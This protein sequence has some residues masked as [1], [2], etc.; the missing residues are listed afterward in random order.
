MT[1]MRYMRSLFV[2]FVLLIIVGLTVILGC[3]EADDFDSLA[4]DGLSAFQEAE[5]NEAMHL[6]GKALHLKPSD[7]DML[8]NM[9][10]TFYKL[11]LPDSALVYFYRANILYPVD[12]AINK[13]LFRLCTLTEDYQ[14]ALSAVQMMIANGDS[15]EMFWIPLA[16][17][18][19]FLGK[20]ALARKYY[21]LLI[22]DDPEEGRYRWNL[23]ECFAKMNRPGEAIKV[24]KE[25]VDKLGANPVVYSQIAVN[26]ITSRE[27][28]QAE[29]YFR[30]AIEFDSQ[31]I[32]LWINLAHTLTEQ[33]SR[34]KKEEALA[35]YKLYY[36]D[37]PEMFKLDSLIKALD[38]ELGQN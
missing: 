38:A 34:E 8:Y 11:D 16:D 22:N 27:F 12:Y 23:S 15:E 10:L 37:T 20:Y 9:G 35:I 18:N 28:A 6:F 1:Y 24:L 36:I 30:K 29:V 19:F 4:K 31:N 2:F 13:E 5:Y 32:S 7:R 14:G 25:A 17:L 21:Q 33:E 26:H 3:G